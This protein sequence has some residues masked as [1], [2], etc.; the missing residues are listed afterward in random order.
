MKTTFFYFFIVVLGLA[1]I[2]TSPTSSSAEDFY[3][4]KTLRF[5]SGAAPGGG[6]DTYTR[7]VARHIAKHI[8]GNSGTVVENMEGAGTLIAANY[9]Y[10]NA[11]PDGLTIGN[12][13][14]AIVLRQAL[15]DR[16]VRLDA[17]KVG[18]IGAPSVGQPTCAMMGF[19]GL[20]TLDDVIATKKQL[21]MG[22]TRAG[23]TTDDLPRILNLTIGTKFDVISGFTGTSRIRL[24]MQKRELDGSC[25]GWESMSVT[26][27]AMLNASGDDKLIPFITHGNAEDP[28]VKNLPRLRDVVNAKAGEKGLAILDTWLNQYNFQRPLTLPPGTPKERVNILRKAFKATLEDPEFL[29]DAQKSKLDITYVSAEEIEKLVSRILGISQETKDSLGFLVRGTK[30]QTS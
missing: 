28:Q 23:S 29:Q 12:W 9:M 21:K 20:K 2:G 22:A 25:W 27:K 17:S 5:V 13:N 6:Y 14:S 11:E 1:V 15:G 7:A 10:N 3:K 18:W 8:P 16:G 19:T 26:G 24:A 4:G 30:K